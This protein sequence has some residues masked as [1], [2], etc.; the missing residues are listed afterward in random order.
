MDSRAE[1][2]RKTRERVAAAAARDRENETVVL[3]TPDGIAMY[4]FLQARG[5]LHLEMSGLTFRQSTI[6]ALQRAGITEARTRQKAHDDLNEHIAK[7]GGPDD[8][9]CAKKAATSDG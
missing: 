1:R 4:G 9:R 8:T 6:A 7:L 5:R 3:D 2:D